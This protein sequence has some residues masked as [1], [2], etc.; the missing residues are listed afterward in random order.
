MLSSVLNILCALIQ[1]ILTT[2]IEIDNTHAPAHP[3]ISHL[4]EEE[5]T[6]AQRG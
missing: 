2:T 5:E 4:I 6:D 1:L 3:A